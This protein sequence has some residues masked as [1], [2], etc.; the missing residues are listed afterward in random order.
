MRTERRTKE[1][2][3]KEEEEERKKEGAKYSLFPVMCNSWAVGVQSVIDLY[4]ARSAS[5]AAVTCGAFAERQQVCYSRTDSHHPDDHA[6]FC[7]FIK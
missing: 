6:E 5:G 7:T 1:S 2:E 3:R 4:S